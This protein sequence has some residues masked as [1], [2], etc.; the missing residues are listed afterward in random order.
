ME[1]SMYGF[2]AGRLWG[3][4]KRLSRKF[5]FIP[6]IEPQF[7]GLVDRAFEKQ[8]NRRRENGAWSGLTEAFIG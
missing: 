6:T 7:M 1:E 5:S 3:K 4:L 2:A 8:D